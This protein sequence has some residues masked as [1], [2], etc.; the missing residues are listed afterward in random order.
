MSVVER[1]ILCGG[2]PSPPRVKPKNVLRL[3]LGDGD[4]D[5]KLK[6]ADITRR[7]ASDVPDVLTDLVEI[8]SYI[9]C[10]DQ[11]LTRGGDGAIVVGRNWRRRFSF[12]IP[13]RVPDIWSS[14]PVV[15]ALRDTL[16]FLSDDDE[17]EFHFSK[18]KEPA[19]MQQYLELAPGADDISEI[20]EVLLFSGGID[21]L[22]GAVIEAVREKRRT[23]L[24]SHRANPKISSKQKLLFQDL[25]AMCPENKPFHIP[26]WVQK[27]EALDREYTQRTR[28][29]LYAS[30]AAVVARA[31]GLRRIRF[32]ENGVVSLNLP[33]SEQVVGGRATR[34]THPQVLNGYAALFR[35]LTDGAFEVENPFLWL[36]K[37][38]VVDVIGDAGCSTLIKHSVS[39]T[40]TRD[41]TRIFTHCGRCSQCIS[42]RFATLA[43]KYAES[44]PA[45]MYKVDL[46]VGER[47]KN[48]D[49][50]LVESFVRSAADMKTM[51][52]Y[53]LLERFGEVS[54]VLRHLSPLT[55][56]E[57]A[58]GVVRLHQKHATEVS[59]VLDSALSQHSTDLLEEK[60][61]STCALI[62]AVPE[63]Y[64]TAVVGQGQ[65]NGRQRGSPPATAAEKESPAPKV[66]R[67]IGSDAAVDTLLKLKDRKG[68]TV[69]EL[70]RH[71]GTTARTVQTFIRR[72]RV[73]NSVFRTMA[74]RLGV[75]PEEL[76]EGKSPNPE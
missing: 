16:T 8:A 69:E 46:L 61:P 1:A 28:S 20:D 2:S 10:A 32:Y 19:P 22:G 57:V 11:A 76:L 15:T 42:R 31:F 37:G 48:I 71:V 66:A 29:F 56:D 12:H 74:G 26:V 5:V 4:A 59:T 72:R 35:L 58:Q 14:G 25:R 68:W 53:Q 27:G 36:T 63:K 75:S 30:L 17:Y 13:V 24:V 21:S 51:N 3:R 52:E 44:D 7:L 6:I 55:A 73:R 65:G 60:L 50:T 33:I 9:Y 67:S 38:E 34:T 43:S 40:H 64:K 18:H 39:C 62:L 23:A 41:M 70:A 47:T 54:R 45:E 49:L